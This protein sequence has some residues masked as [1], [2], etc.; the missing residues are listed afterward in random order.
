MF[1][2]EFV[3]HFPLNSY[4][5][6]SI[7]NGIRINNTQTSYKDISGIKCIIRF[8]IEMSLFRVNIYFLLLFF[9]NNTSRHIRTISLIDNAHIDKYYIVFLKFP[10]CRTM[11]WNSSIFSEGDNRRETRAARSEFELQNLNSSCYCFLGDTDLEKRLNCLI[12]SSIDSLTFSK[13]YYFFRCLNYSVGSY[14]TFFHHKLWPISLYFFSKCLGEVV[15]ISKEFLILSEFLSPPR[16]RLNNLK[17]STI[18]E[19]TCSCIT[20]NNSCTL[21]FVF[22]I[23]YSLSFL[24]FVFCILY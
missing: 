13:L 2:I 20:K 4:S 11:M 19:P 8:F 21:Y 3:E 12:H 18:E 10:Q 24:Y 22:C 17:S 7:H 14:R 16:S 1:W 15:W 6:N 9:W 5:P 23:L